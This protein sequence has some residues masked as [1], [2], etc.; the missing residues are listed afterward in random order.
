MTSNPQ[1]SAK[2][3]AA[4]YNRIN[5]IFHAILAPPLVVFVWLY[6]E[7]NA[8]GI[9]PVM[10]SVSAISV[11]SFVFPILVVGI[12]AV[13]FY[14]FKSGLRRINPT[15]DLIEKAPIY[16]QK[17]IVLFVMLEVSLMVGVLGYYL[18]QKDLFLAMYIIVLIFFSL[19]KPTLER[20]SDHLGIKGEERDFLINC[21]SIARGDRDA[22]SDPAENA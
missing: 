5:L 19:Y 16:A 9:S 12:I 10:E 8:G 15:I 7:S 6:L 14:L 11:I 2:K 1:K 17:S 20:M 3:L 4:L 21:R 13:A 18:T 22:E